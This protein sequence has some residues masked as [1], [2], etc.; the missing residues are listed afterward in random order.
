[1]LLEWPDSVTG[2]KASS[3][4]SENQKEFIQWPLAPPLVP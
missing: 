3:P 2:K 1:V 4:D